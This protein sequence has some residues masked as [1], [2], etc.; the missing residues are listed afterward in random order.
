MSETIDDGSWRAWCHVTNSPCTAIIPAACLCAQMHP[1]QMMELKDRDAGAM[2]GE[3]PPMSDEDRERK[4]LALTL[5]GKTLR[6]NHM[7]ATGPD[8]R[9]A[10]IGCTGFVTIE[11]W[12][13]EYA[14]HL[15]TVIAK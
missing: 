1:V 9:V 12:A 4:E 10:S 3:K 11:G 15:F 5:A 14:P 6:F 13:G 7:A 8:L 2:A